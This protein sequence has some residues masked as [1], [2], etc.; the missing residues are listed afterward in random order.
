[1]SKLEMDQDLARI[2]L[3]TLARNNAEL[4]YIV[5]L[6]KEHADEESTD[7]RVKIARLIGDTGFDIM[8]PIFSAFPELKEEFQNRLEKYNRSFP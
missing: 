5:S 8:D 6:L 1:M 3:A 2:V 7:I 4:T